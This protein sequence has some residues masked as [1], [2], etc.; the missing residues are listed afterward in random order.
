MHLYISSL[1]SE[2][3]NSDTLC[4]SLHTHYSPTQ[5]HCGNAHNI[6][7]CSEVLLTRQEE[8][9]KPSS[10][11]MRSEEAEQKGN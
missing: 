3:I 7:M 10:E 2:A 9:P 4:T 11:E 8:L 6:L 1:H 5:A